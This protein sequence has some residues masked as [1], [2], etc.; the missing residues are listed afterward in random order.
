MQRPL[1]AERALKV[2]LWCDAETSA[3]LARKAPD[4]FDWIGHRVECPPGVARFAVR[5]LRCALRCRAPGIVWRNEHGP[6]SGVTDFIPAF[7]AALPGRRL[8]PCKAALTRSELAGELLS[9]GRAWCYIEGVYTKGHLRKVVEAM[10]DARRRGRVVIINPSVHALGWW[11]VDGQVMSLREARDSLARLGCRSPGSL[12]VLCGLERDAIRLASEILRTDAGVETV[13]AAVRDALDPGASLAR[14]GELRGVV[15]L[16]V[17][18]IGGDDSPPVLRAFA[19]DPRVLR[20]RGAG[21][22]RLFGPRATTSLFVWDEVQSIISALVDLC[23]PLVRGALPEPR[24]REFLANIEG[25]VG[26]DHPMHAQALGLLALSLASQGRYKEA[27]AHLRRALAAQQAMLRPGYP[28][29]VWTNSH[30]ASILAAQG[31]HAEA[32]P[33]A[34]WVLNVLE[35]E[36]GPAHRRTALALAHLATIRHAL[37]EPGAADDARRALDMLAPDDPARDELSASLRHII[38]GD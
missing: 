31:R 38:G 8:V 33:L 16:M 30:L 37:G 17:V 10:Q 7:I 28:D 3:A 21:F 1:F 35:E 12:A 18:A 36:L 26:S 22:P 14:L 11:Y 34:I 15:D 13:T 32:K 9:N 5:G 25:I 20:L 4:F 24:A 2:V 19:A 6:V 23:P 29:I 27:E